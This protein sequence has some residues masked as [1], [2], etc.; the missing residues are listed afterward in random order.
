M[1]PDEEAA[2]ELRNKIV[3]ILRNPK[4]PKSN[5]N[6]AER[7]ALKSLRENKDITILL[8]EKA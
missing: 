1:K 3:G 5:I 6:K 8:A 4:P 2:S 7:Q